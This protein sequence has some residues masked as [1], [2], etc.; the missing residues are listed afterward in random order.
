MTTPHDPPPPACAARPRRCAWVDVFGAAPLA[1]NAV[2]VVIDGEGLDDDAMR[3]FARWTQLS[4]T[5]F[6]LPATPEG[7]A[8]GADYRVRIWTPGGELPFAGHPTLGSC[9]AWLA[10]GGVPRRAGTVVQ[11]CGIGLVTVAR[12]PAGGSSGDGDGIDSGDAIRGSAGDDGGGGGGGRQRPGAAA[13]RLAFEAP[14][15]ARSAPDAA[16]LRAVLAALGAD[17]AS[18]RGAQWLDNGPRWLGLLLDSAA[19]VLALEPDLAALAPL[20]H[21]GAVGAHAPGGACAFEVRAFAPALGIAEDPVTGS[22]NA[23]LGE[24]LID[25]GPRPAQLRRRAGHAA[26]PRRPGARAARRRRPHV[27]RRRLRELR[28]GAGGPLTT[29]AAHAVPRLASQRS[30][31]CRCRRDPYPTTSL[32]E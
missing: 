30:R 13:P 6:L 22:L 18:L 14:P 24:W 27:G 8:R 23:G 17:P 29:L 4:E 11:E 31:R 2:A 9:H 12:M 28:R 32:R 21:V 10:A 25:D 1:G 7:A 26:R 20:A 16:L 15:L 19:T 3:R 5:T